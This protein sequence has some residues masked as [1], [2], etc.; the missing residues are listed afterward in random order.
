MRRVTTRR[1]LTSWTHL[2]HLMPHLVSLGARS[3]WSSATLGQIRSTESL[4]ILKQHLGIRVW[5]QVFQS[6]RWCDKELD[7]LWF[8]G[9]LKPISTHI[10]TM[11]AKKFLLLME[12]LKMSMGAILQAHGSEARTWVC[13]NHSVRKVALSLLRLGICWSKSPR[14]SRRLGHCLKVYCFRT[15]F[16]L[17]ATFPWGEHFCVIFHKSDWA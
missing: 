15:L 16:F 9:R 14:A 17:V 6:C 12:Y 4:L 1:V 7:Q 5:C 10:G 11:A 2:V 8:A 13:I 3:L